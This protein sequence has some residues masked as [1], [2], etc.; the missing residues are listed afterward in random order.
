MLV[1]EGCFGYWCVRFFMHICTFEL[2]EPCFRLQDTLFFAPVY[3]PFRLLPT[4]LNKFCIAENSSLLVETVQ[5]IL[6]EGS[7]L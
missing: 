1:G 5:F 2:T 4:S 7:L 3:L 6:C